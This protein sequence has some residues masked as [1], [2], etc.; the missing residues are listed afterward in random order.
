MS[1]SS[2]FLLVVLAL[3]LAGLATIFKPARAQ[4]PAVAINEIQV[5]TTGDDWEFVELQ[6]PATTDLSSLTLVGIE[7]DVGPGV[8]TIDIVVDLEGQSIPADGFWVAASPA[9]EAQYGI[10]GDLAIADNSF[11]N[12]TATYLLVSDF[13]GT[14]GDDLD[15]ND[16]GALDTTPWTEVVSSVNL[17]DSESDYVY[18]GA[19]TVGPDGD[20]LPSG[21]Y[22]CPDGPAGS[23]DDNMLSFSTA[24]GTPGAPNDCVTVP[25][26]ACGDPATFI[27][28]V[29]GSGT[30][31]PMEGDVVSIEGVVVGDF[32]AGNGDPFDSDLGGFFLQEETEDAD[33]DE[34]TSEGIFVDAPGATDIAEGDI[35]RVQGLVE[36]AETAGGESSLTQ[37]AIVGDVLF[38]E[39][40]TLP[41]PDEVT[42]PVP[43]LDVLEQHEGM[44][45]TFPQQLVISEYFN[46]D[47]FNEIVL[48]VPQVSDRPFQPTSYLDPDEQ[49]AEVNEALD[50]IARSRVTLDDAR[51]TQNPVPLRHPDGTPFTLENRFRGGDRVQDATG[52]LEDSFG[53]YRIQP[54]APATYIESN[55]R[56]DVF[57]V[58]G[59]AVEVTTFN[60]LNYFLT[61]D[62]GSDICGPGQDME[63]RGADDAE[64]FERQRAKILAALRAM[65]SDVYGL[66]EMENT[67][68]VEPLADIVAGLNAELGDGTYAYIDTGTIGTDA[69]KNG[70]IYRPAAVT[71]LGDFD[72][73][74]ETAFVDPNNT[75]E[76]KSRPALVQ[77][78][79]SNNSGERFTV[80]LNHLKSKG[81][82][83]G[84]GDDDPLEGNCNLTRTLAAEY[85][86]DWLAT[87]PTSLSHGNYLII[88]DL[89]AYDEEDPIE[90]IQ[91]GPDGELGTADD[92]VDLLEAYQGEHAYTYVFD[93]QFGYL[94]YAMASRQMAARVTGATTWPINADEPDILDYDTTF[95][96]D[97]QDEL[98][99]P[100]MFRSS[101]HDPVLVGLFGDRV[102]YLPIIHNDP[103]EP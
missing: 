64:E 57:V 23:F 92:Y 59:G 4:A 39:E 13:T 32:Q 101:D 34:T 51:T 100:N 52:V 47:R 65:Q 48:A 71:P 21:T 11:E 15:T 91:A 93:G 61:L 26:G 31:S 80:V 19:P 7:S 5:N 10:T 18:A 53:L 44:L 33:M 88:G 3:A 50:L 14:A 83:C 16:D 99:E 90:A 78:F 8:G 17:R 45:V 6:G 54:T 55:W 94:D 27:H 63:C 75:G 40:G 96:P 43:S 103:V 102:Y 89:N 42:L 62:E 49:T 2:L 25:I 77:T 85:L 12:G 56:P 29:Q 46:Y 72:V 24:N 76:P 66:I 58:P 60:V 86:V 30:T 36:E 67:T 35:V 1:R 9:A 82:P 87:Y 20:F 37:I 98:Y 69:I 41:A 84:P 38:C 74:E 73:L 22:R 81:S 79:Q 70:I 28:E 95:K 68:G 97:E